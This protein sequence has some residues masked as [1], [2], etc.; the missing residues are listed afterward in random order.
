MMNEQFAW[1]RNIEKGKE[2]KTEKYEFSCFSEI[3]MRES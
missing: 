3:Y 1:K 2:L